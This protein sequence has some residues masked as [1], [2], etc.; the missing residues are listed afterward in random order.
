MKMRRPARPL[1]GKKPPYPFC[2]V[3]S[4]RFHGGRGFSVTVDGITRWV[5]GACIEVATK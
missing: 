2:W 1:T 4:R 5:H 3:C